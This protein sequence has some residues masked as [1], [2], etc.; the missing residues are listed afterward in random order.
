MQTTTN[1]KVFTC[2]HCGSKIVAYPNQVLY[3]TCDTYVCNKTCQK[4]R[5]SAIAKLDPK[6]E[7]PLSWTHN[8][9]SRPCE[10]IK[11][12]GSC[13]GLQDLEFGNDMTS[14]IIGPKDSKERDDS[15][16]V[17]VTFSTVERNHIPTRPPNKP[18]EYIILCFAFIGSAAIFLAI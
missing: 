11:R 17:T 10:P 3:R 4:A 1:M 2:G 7:N 18:Y 5:L 9:S 8:L 12:K 6:M 15:D 13:I 14:E 16:M